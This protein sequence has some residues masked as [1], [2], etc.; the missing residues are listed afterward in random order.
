VYVTE[1]GLYRLIGSSRK[2]EAEAFQDWVSEEVLPSIRKTGAY[3][4]VQKQL[5]PAELLLQQATLLVEH[6]ARLAQIERKANEA[7]ERTKQIEE[8][9]N[10]DLLDRAIAVEELEDLPHPSLDAP[11][12]T[13]R[14]NLRRYILRYS[15]ALGKTP[16]WAW[17]ELY[18]YV[19]YTLG[20]NI[21]ERAKNGKISGVEV[22][23]RLDLIEEAYAIAQKYL[24]IPP[25]P[26]ARNFIPPR[27][28]SMID[29]EDLMKDI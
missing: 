19:S 26:S 25:K 28:E 7:L 20:K 24:P 15:Q 1:P 13:T 4:V 21:K 2:P 9:Q 5:T 29:L 12:V 27:C 17:N 11:E 22:L 18:R 8:V 10:K 6:E 3:S 16:R 23:E 14:V